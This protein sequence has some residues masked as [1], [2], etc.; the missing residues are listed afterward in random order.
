MNEMTPKS[1]RN[2]T[3]N[4]QNFTFR[5]KTLIKLPGIW[6]FIIELT[7]ITVVST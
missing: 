4:V 3:Y 5:V 7:P 6:Y 1:P 2:Q